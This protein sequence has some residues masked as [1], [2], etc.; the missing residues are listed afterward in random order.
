[1]EVVRGLLEG[2]RQDQGVGG[3]IRRMAQDCEMSVRVQMGSV[4]LFQYHHDGR[5][6]RGSDGCSHG[7][8]RG[9]AC[10][11]SLAAVRTAGVRFERSNCCGVS[12]VAVGGWVGSCMFACNGGG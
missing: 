12:V 9:I 2:R 7:F 3:V 1:M 10:L 8:Q 11:A 4:H 5:A 6:R